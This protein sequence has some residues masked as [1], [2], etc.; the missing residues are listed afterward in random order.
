[1]VAAMGRRPAL[2]LRGHGLTTSGST[3]QEA[4][5]RALSIDAIARLSLQVAAAGGYLADLPAVDLA[6][7]PD[8]GKGFNEGV[9]WRHEL[10]RL[11]QVNGA[12]PH[13]RREA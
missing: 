4:V 6:E 10:S 8:L 11:E 7:L 13:R 12:C 1:M 3:V 5:L 9:A 2:V